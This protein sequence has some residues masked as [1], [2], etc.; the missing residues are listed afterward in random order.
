MNMHSP[1]FKPNISGNVIANPRMI[2]ANPD[3]SARA[4]DASDHTPGNQP[5]CPNDRSTVE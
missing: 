3:R 2:A 1:W 5:E 4:S